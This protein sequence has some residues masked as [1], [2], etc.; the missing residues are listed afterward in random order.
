MKR[1]KGYPK[2]ILLVVATAAALTAA[3]VAAAA[4][5]PSPPFD[6]AHPGSPHAALLSPASGNNDRPMLVV[7]GEFDDVA[8]TANVDAGSIATQFFG[9][10]FGSVSDFFRVSSVGRLILSA[11]AESSGTANDGVVTVD[12]GSYADFVANPADKG[13]YRDEGQHGDAIRGRKVIEAADSAVNYATFD[14]NN[15]GNVT[16]DELIVFLVQEGNPT[17]GDTNNCGATRSIKTGSALDGKNFPKAWSSGTTL[18]NT[19][20]HI[21]EISHQA[22]DH[23]DH[24]YSA[25]KLDI[26]GPTCGY[27]TTTFWD[28]NSW[29]KL[30]FGWV[31]PTVVAKDGFYDVGRWDATGQTYLL[32]DP[33]KG[34]N[35]YFLVEN[36]TKTAG[37]YD[38]DASDRGLVIWRVDDTLFGPPIPNPYQLM[39]PNQMAAD[40]TQYDGGPDDAWDPSDTRTPQRTMSRPWSDGTASNVAV[41]AIG[42]SG[43]SVRAYFDVRGPGVLVDPTSAVTDVTM[44]QANPVSFPVMNTGETTDTFSFTLADLPSGWTAAASTQSIGA[45]GAGTATVQ[46]TVPADTPTRSYTLKARGTST[47]DSTVTSSS[48]ITVRVVKRSTTLAYSASTTADYSDP[49]SVSA[50]LTDAAT[51]LPIAGKAIHFSLGTQS[52]S[53]DPATDGD[54]R[55]SG[56]IT[57]TQASGT[58]SVDSSF[59]GDGTYL[60]SSD[61]DSFT[62]T[63]E[64]LSFSYSGSTLL[65][66]GATPILASTATE[67]PDGSPGDLSLAVAAFALTPTL[68]SL[69][70]TYT[71]A[72]D[73]SGASTTSATGLSV[74]IWSVTIAV[75]ASN[76]YWRGATAGPAELVLFDPAAMFTGDAAGKDATN[77]SISIA[78]DYRYD[79]TPRPRGSIALRF[80]GGTFTAKNPTWIVQ[81]GTTAIVQTTGSLNGAAATLRLRVDDNAEPARPDTFR[82][83]IGAYDSGTVAVTSGNLQ[84][85]PA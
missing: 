16:D 81:V 74:D 21:H 36:R 15:D 2:G 60:P 40:T 24:E 71:A 51:G 80:S 50:V 39:R 28:Y 25:G 44:L 32:Y 41:R 3:T 48:P 69:P 6:F 82:A 54:G 56:S 66:L 22:L 8:A 12:L 84:S 23:D 52:T 33:D 34:T 46:L 55:A 83:Q 72:V 13:V 37:T 73:A 35:D 68:T 49:A 61:S 18:T 10:G 53:P 38:K 70:F 5:Y 30:H 58:V 67:Q 42:S 26:T 7:L 11:A 43:N 19:I 47:T 75:P 65:A 9:G 29:H 85:H 4:T 79:K 78:F 1:I 57:I 45:G 76:A 77:R 14:R 59:A 63:K 20:T 62:I 31:T 64:T 17:P 27:P